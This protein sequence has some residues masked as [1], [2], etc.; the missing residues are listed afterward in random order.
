[1]GYNHTYAHGRLAMWLREQAGDKLTD[2]NWETY[3]AMTLWHDNVIVYLSDQA[4]EEQ[5]A[6]YFSGPLL[7]RAIVTNL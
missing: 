2:A 3:D 4:D 1:V 5:C 7:P 6:A